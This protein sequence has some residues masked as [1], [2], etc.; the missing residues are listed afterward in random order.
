MVSEGTGRDTIHTAGSWQQ[1]RLPVVLRRRWAALP[2]MGQNALLSAPWGQ[3]ERVGVCGQPGWSSTSSFPLLFF[4]SFTQYGLCPFLVFEHCFV[5]ILC[6]LSSWGGGGGGCKCAWCSFSKVGFFVI[7]WIFQEL[8]LQYFH[9]GVVLC[10]YAM[11]S[12]VLP[13]FW[14]ISTKTVMDVFGV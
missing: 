7:V 8:H 5:L 14:I 1:R 2:V 11:S 9:H 13:V 12:Y 3:G 6:S 10:G 4:F